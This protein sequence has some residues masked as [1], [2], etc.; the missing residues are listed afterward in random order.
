VVAHRVVERGHAHAVLG[1]PL[2]VQVRED[3]LLLVAEARALGQELV[4]LV[5]ERVA[6]PRQVRGGLA[7]P[8]GGVQIRAMH[9]P[10]CAAHRSFRYSALPMMMLLAERFPTTVA[11]ASA[12]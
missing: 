12:A 1:Q 5:D 4:V 10:D 11:P 7:L 3:D 2:Q 6:V 9:F 8:R